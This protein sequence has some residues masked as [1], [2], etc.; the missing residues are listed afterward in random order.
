MTSSLQ[1]FEVTD[2]IGARR[3]RRQIQELRPMQC[4]H[5]RSIACSC[6]SLS[7]PSPNRLTVT[8]SVCDRLAKALH[9]QD[10]YPDSEAHWIVI[11]R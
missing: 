6:P 1:A 5:P 10:R 9:I 8:T 11:I 7:V 3:D 2:R 4:H